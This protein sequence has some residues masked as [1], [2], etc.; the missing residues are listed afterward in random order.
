MSTL[1]YQPPASEPITETAV[2]APAEATPL[3]LKDY[4][5]ARLAGV[6]RRTW[7]TW[8]A[9]KLVPQLVRIGGRA[10]FWR[11][12]DVEAWVAMGCPSRDEFASKMAGDDRRGGSR[13]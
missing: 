8:H 1:R 11:R 3:L 5:A 4:E 10:I 2:A 7:L 6:C 9:R 13:G 12:A